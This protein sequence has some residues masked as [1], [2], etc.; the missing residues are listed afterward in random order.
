MALA[1]IVLHNICLELGDLVIRPWDPSIDPMTNQTRPRDEVRQILMMRACRR[2]PD[3]SAQAT[4]V[5]N[6]LAVNFDEERS[7]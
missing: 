3:N 7:G 1:A 4:V 5:R 2:I 6:A